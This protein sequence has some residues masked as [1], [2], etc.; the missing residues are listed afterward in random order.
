MQNPCLLDL[1]RWHGRPGAAKACGPDEQCQN[2][3]VYPGYLTW[4]DNME[5]WGQQKSLRPWWTVSSSLETQTRG[6]NAMMKI[7]NMQYVGWLGTKS[8]YSFR[9]VWNDLPAY[10]YSSSSSMSR[11]ASS[12]M[13]N[14]R[15]WRNAW[16]TV[17]CSPAVE[18]AAAARCRCP[19]RTWEVTGGRVVAREGFM[20]EKKKIFFKMY[21]GV[22]ILVLPWFLS[23]S[24]V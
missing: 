8:W 3:L 9:A 18:S 23:W 11:R 21:E 16:R 10:E 17:R 24:A 4:Q 6:M 19:W 22:G 1:T 20:V 12:R 13:T 5:D 15:C 2:S 14:N 7:Y